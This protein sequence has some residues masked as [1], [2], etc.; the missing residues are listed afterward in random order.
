[1][2][3]IYRL[4]AVGVS[5]QRCAAWVALACTLS[6]VASASAFATTGVVSVLGGPQSGGSAGQFNGPS[7]IA[8]DQSTGDVYVADSANNRVQEFAE[9]G[10][11]IRT[12]GVGVTTAGPDAKP[13]TAEVKSVIISATTGTSFQLEF[14]GHE[15]FGHVIGGE[16]TA[17]IPVGA[18]AATIEGALQALPAI[19]DQG[20]MVSVTGTGEESDPYLVTF[21]GSLSGVKNTLG[22][23]FGTPEEGITVTVAT[24]TPGVS[25]FEQC[26]AANGDTCRAGN[27]NSEAGGMSKPQGVAVDQNTGNVYVT[28]E[29]NHR[30]DV[31]GSTGEFEGAWGW[32]VATGASAFEF[33][34]APSSP[35]ECRAGYAGSEAGELGEIVGYPAV[36]PAS[37]DVY[38]ADPANHR[39]DEFSVTNSAGSVTAAAFVRSY[40]WGVATGAEE[41]EICTSTCLGGIE[42]SGP[43]QFMYGAPKSVAVDNQGNVYALDSGTFGGRV[44]KFDASGAPMASFATAQLPGEPAPTAVAVDPGDDGVLVLQPCS[45]EICPQAPSTAVLVLEF[46]TSGKLRKSDE[47]N[48]GISEPKSEVGLAAA[49]S[50]G[51]VYLTSAFFGR[52][53]PQYLFALNTIV[54]PAVAVAPASSVSSDKGILHGTVTPNEDEAN[55]LQ[56]EYQFEYSLDGQ[57]WRP[58]SVTPGK[59]AASMGPVAVEQALT[60]LESDT[61]Y[62]VR[63]TAMKEFAG[64][65]ATSTS[66]EFT[67]ESAPPTVSRTEASNIEAGSVLLEARVNPQG[68]QTTYR[69]EYGTSEA[70]GTIPPGAEGEVGSNVGEVALSARPQGLLPGTLYYYR[71]LASSSRGTGE[72]KGTFTTVELTPPGVT[73]GGYSALAQNTATISGTLNTQGL[74]ATYG[75]E[76]GTS[77]DGYGPPTGL[78]ALGAGASAASVSLAL[79][80]LLPGTTYHYRLTASN[81]NGTAHGADQAF[82]TTTFPNGFATP[83]APLPFMAV[84]QITFPAEEH[85]VAKP[86]PRTLTARQKLANALKACK[87]KVRRVKQCERAARARYGPIHKK[88]ARRNG[89]GHH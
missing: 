27:E 22:T 77:V 88:P 48:P 83:P 87:R 54:L 29:G 4:T 26:V 8:V 9:D 53:G 11:F 68:A 7:G 73:T 25:S 28:D 14:G 78:G 1:M 55:H 21:G 50:G 40:G 20:G 16:S 58:L 17:S 71:V 6:L 13:S 10:T 69:F 67:T 66:T 34:T 30:I 70:Y 42:G 39:V 19:G 52:G 43:G 89:S 72:A 51:N 37:G 47:L 2:I 36:D 80:G 24:V 15:F 31:F 85:T 44:Q 76:I 41:F 45:A 49:A 57:H 23:A 56:T 75:F 61:T 18:S 46:D 59:V 79:S 74:P 35:G 82:T 33:C 84:P 65:E 62:Q 38:V 64:G 63:L 86:A 60:G 3:R 12:W 5:I 81:V 32:G